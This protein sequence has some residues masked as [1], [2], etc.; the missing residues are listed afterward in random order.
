MQFMKAGCAM[1]GSILIFSVGCNTKDTESVT[2]ADLPVETKS[3]PVIGTQTDG[4]WAFLGIPYAMPPVGSQR[5]KAPQPIK[6]WTKPLK[7]TKIGPA[8]RAI[9]L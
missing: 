7:A 1:L 6:P 8:C 5:W 3:G 4:V 9:A 2:Q